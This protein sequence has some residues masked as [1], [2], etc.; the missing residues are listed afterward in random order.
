MPNIDNTICFPSPNIPLIKPITPKN[1][2]GIKVNNNGI[3]N[4]SEPFFICII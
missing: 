1:I 2:V 4:K 3:E